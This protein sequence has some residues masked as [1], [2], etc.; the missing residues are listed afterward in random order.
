MTGV[1]GDHVGGGARRQVLVGGIA[2]IEAVAA[3]GIEGE[4]GRP[5]RR[6]A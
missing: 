2:G 4:A 3:V 1:G 5:A 6:S